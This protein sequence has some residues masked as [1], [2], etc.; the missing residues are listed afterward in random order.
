MLPLPVSVASKVGVMPGTALLFASLS[1]IVTVDSAAPSATTGDVPVI[2]EFEAVGR[3]EE[4]LTVSEPVTATGEV[5]CSVFTSAL[6]DAKVQVET[7]VESVA[8]QAP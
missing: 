7:P 4:K 3:E 8:E 2:V 5:N 1:V 6:V